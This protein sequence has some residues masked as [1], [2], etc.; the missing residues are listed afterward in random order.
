LKEVPF[1]SPDGRK[2]ELSDV[3][4]LSRMCLGAGIFLLGASAL[5]S[6]FYAKQFAFSWLFAFSFYYSLCLGSLFWVIV[7]H[8]TRSSW[9][10]LVRRQAENLTALFPIVA[11]LFLPILLDVW[12]G[13]NLYGWSDPASAVK[14]RVWQARLPYL[15][16]LFFTLR[17]FGYFLFFI[18][19]SRWLRQRSLLQDATGEGRISLGL[20]SG[21]CLLAPVFAAA[22]TFSAFDW[23]MSLEERWASTI[24]GVYLLAFSI[25]GAMALWIVLV[26]ALA[27]RGYLPWVGPEHYHAMGKLLFAFTIFWAYIA[28]AQY[29]LVWYGNLPEE[30]GFFIR[31]NHGSW[32]ALS[33]ALVYGKFGLTFLW[34]LSQ[35]AKKDPRRLGWGAAWVLVMHG[36]EAYWI[37]LPVLHPEG[38]HLHWLDLTLWAGMGLVLGAFLLRC[39][40][41]AGLYPVRDPL[42]IESVHLKN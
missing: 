25:Q 2:L 6:F 10:T 17:A 27:T 36:V 28:F 32:Q 37:V 40:A 3:R 33:V 39:I 5:G 9:G 24:W 12:V 22:T 1:G 42:L 35:G 26:L 20:S 4:D 7:H 16:P 31:R 21:S 34:L 30:T 11:I 23:W 14:S 13:H 18:L 38:M 41:S 8:A 19:A 15:H 29:F